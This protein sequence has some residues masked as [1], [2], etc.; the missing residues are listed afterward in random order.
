VSAEWITGRMRAYVVRDSRA[1]VELS[2]ALS[3]CRSG[4]KLQRHLCSGLRQ[5]SQVRGIAAEWR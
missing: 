3:P 1:A 5:A 2:V 4:D